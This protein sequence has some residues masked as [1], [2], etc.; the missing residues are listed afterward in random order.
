M[1]CQNYSVLFLILWTLKT[2]TGQTNLLEPRQTF[3]S[4]KLLTLDIEG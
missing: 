1:G 3:S 4:K 2:L